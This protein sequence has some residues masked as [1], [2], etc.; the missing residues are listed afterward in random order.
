METLFCRKKRLER[1][2]KDSPLSQTTF[3]SKYEFE[4]EVNNNITIKDNKEGLNSGLEAT[5]LTQ[6][7]PIGST[8]TED[9]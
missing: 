2:T 1:D 5:S 6:N 3:S 7:V 4:E 8:E 9:F